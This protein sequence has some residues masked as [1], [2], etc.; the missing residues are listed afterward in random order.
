MS[1][2][3][4]GMWLPEM[5]F[6]PKLVPLLEE[7]G[8]RYTVLDDRC[9]L[10]VIYPY[11]PYHFY[12]IENSSIR[13]LFRNHTISDDFA[14]NNFRSEDEILM[15]RE[16]DPERGSCHDSGRQRELDTILPPIPA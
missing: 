10:N 2:N 3:A 1:V 8:A 5:A 14:F 12:G 7:H 4:S 11:S 16:G 6:S 13:V 15:V 9:H